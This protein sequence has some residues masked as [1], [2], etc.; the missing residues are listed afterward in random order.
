[1]SGPTALAVEQA[2]QLVA[3]CADVYA[4]PAARYL[5]GDSFH[6]GGLTLTS[7]VAALAGVN[8]SSVVLDVGSGRG[9]SAVHLAAEKGCR[10]H[11][12]TLERQGVEAGLALAR[13]RG[14]AERVSFALGDVMAAP[15]EVGGFDVALMECGQPS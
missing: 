2:K 13:E 15:I 6:P 4:H 9:A 14:V 3:C 12:L 5:M 7:Q 11:G 10:V 1:M 8:A